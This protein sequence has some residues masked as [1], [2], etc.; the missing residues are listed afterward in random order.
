MKILL[1][2]DLHG[3]TDWFHFAETFPADLTAISGDLLDGF[4]DEGLLPQ[5]VRLARWAKRFPAPLA[6]C[7]GNHDANTPNRAID[8]ASLAHLDTQSRDEALALLTT[9][10]WMDALESPSTVT[11]HS[12]RLLQTAA[13]PII[14]TTLPFDEGEAE[15]PRTMAALWREGQKLR[16]ETSAPWL[17]LHH[18]PPAPFSGDHTGSFGSTDFS[19]RLRE[20]QPDFALSGHL[21]LAPYHTSFATRLGKTWCFNPGHPPP[22]AASRAPKPNHILL[23]LAKSQATW[24][25]APPQGSTPLTQT[26]SLRQSPKN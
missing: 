4:S 19:G 3:R 23:D 10:Y 20:H 7:S 12:S 24:T 11:D 22:I 25:A 8:P 16:R 17:V 1:L 15:H 9:E 13:G 26:I 2:S 21:H 6:L 18:E 5:S 14:I